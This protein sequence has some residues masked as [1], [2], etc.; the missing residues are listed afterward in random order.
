MGFKPK[1]TEMNVRIIFE[2]CFFYLDYEITL[3][4]VY[5]ISVVDITCIKHDSNVRNSVSAPA[6]LAK[7]IHGNLVTRTLLHFDILKKSATESVR[8]EVTLTYNRIILQ[9]ILHCG[10][11]L[12]LKW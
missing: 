3:P 11:A 2:W 10:T 7:Q 6:Q 5:E 9:V 4:E 8:P 12:C 1:E